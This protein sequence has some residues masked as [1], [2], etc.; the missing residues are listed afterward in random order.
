MRKKKVQPVSSDDNLEQRRQSLLV[1]LARLDD[2]FENRKI[3][4]DAYRKLRTE[5]KAQ[6]LALMQRSNEEYDR[7]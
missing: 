7:K 6:L 4:E 3:P 5:T 2:D 1:K